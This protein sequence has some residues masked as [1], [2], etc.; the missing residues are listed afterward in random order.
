MNTQMKN[1]FLAG[2][3][4]ATLVGSNA[5][6]SN[7][8]LQCAMSDLDA[9]PYLNF[10]IAIAAPADVTVAKMS[11]TKSAFFGSEE[12]V[13]EQPLRGCQ[14]AKVSFKYVRRSTILKSIHIECDGDGDAGFVTLTRTKA[15]NFQGGIN[16]PEGKREIGQL[17]DSELKIHCRGEVR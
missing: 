12:F 2:L 11:Y 15:G 8:N 5:Q 4:L 1:L 3:T 6:A 14:N 9:R 13:V 17:E 10:N 7:G 16:F